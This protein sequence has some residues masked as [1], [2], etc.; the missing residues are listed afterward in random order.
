MGTKPPMA[1]VSEDLSDEELETLPV[2]TKPRKSHNQSLDGQRRRKRKCSTI[3]PQRT[4]RDGGQAVMH[5][6]N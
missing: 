6:N 4:G 5:A 1:C 2:G 3:F